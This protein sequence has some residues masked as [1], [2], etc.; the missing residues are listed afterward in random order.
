MDGTIDFDDD[1]IKC[2]LLK[3]DYLPNLDHAVLA[4]VI[5]TPSPEVE[6][7]TSPPN[8]YTTGGAQLTGVTLDEISDPVSVNLTADPIEWFSLTATFMFAL[9]Y[10]AGTKNGLVNPLIAYVVLDYENQAS[11]V[12]N[13]VDYKIQTPTDGLMTLA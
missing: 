3:S 10:V 5:T 11:I 9:F 6:E 2:M 4:D 7:I 8:G 1:T 12:V 13:G